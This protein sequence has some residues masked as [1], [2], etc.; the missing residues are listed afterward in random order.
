MIFSNFTDEARVWVYQAD[1]ILPKE[2]EGEI[3]QAITEFVAKWAAHGAKLTATGAKISDYHIAFCV[4]GDVAASGCSIDSSVKFVKSL[5]EELNIDFFNR[6][7]VLTE[8]NGNT[9]IVDYDSLTKY[10]NR[11]IYNPLITNLGE[12]RKNWLISIPEFL[13]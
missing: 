6:L 5:G 10:S 1:K 11:K 4:E 9:E 7:K 2:Y 3:Q 13:S 12:L 8:E